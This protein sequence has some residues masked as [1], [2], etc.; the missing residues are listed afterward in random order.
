[1]EDRAGS[2]SS[3]D[4]TFM[5]GPPRHTGAASA[6]VEA[7]RPVTRIRAGEMFQCFDH[8]GTAVLQSGVLIAELVMTT[9]GT[10][11]LGR[12]TSGDIIPPL[13]AL[14]APAF[15]L[16]YRAEHLTQIAWLRSDIAG[17]GVREQATRARDAL[18][19]ASMRQITYLACLPAAYRLHIELLRCASLSSDATFELPTHGELASRACTTRET[20]SR[21]VSLLRRHGVL[22]SGKTVR[23]L[24]A[25]D[26]LRRIA[27]A[28]QLENEAEVWESIGL[29]RLDHRIT[30]N[31]LPT[32]MPI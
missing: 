31:R 7:L 17:P 8:S 11:S 1:M 4:P 12:F 6:N 5:D 27:Q 10:L 20:I 14:S 24:K 19:F 16:C 22:S 30:E 26:L 3:L 28:F 29:S 21:E 15:S 13:E 18:L 2:R 25:D 32:P 9:G 23:I